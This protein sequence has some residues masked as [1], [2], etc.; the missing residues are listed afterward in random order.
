MERSRWWLQEAGAGGKR[1]A[2]PA[3]GEHQQGGD[4]QPGNQHLRWEDRQGPKEK[5]KE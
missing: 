4:E 3:G 2:R 1:R 5:R